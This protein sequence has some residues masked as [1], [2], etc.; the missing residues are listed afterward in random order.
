L[1]VAVTVVCGSDEVNVRVHIPA[2]LQPPPDQPVNVDPLFGVAV[3]VT[4]VPVAN[5]E[6]QLLVQPSM[7]L[8][9]LL[10]TDPPPVTL[11][12]SSG[13]SCQLAGGV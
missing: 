7:P 3:R 13:G 5:V 10:V 4:T 8:P 2:P 12:V 9:G 11:T 6:E 1:K